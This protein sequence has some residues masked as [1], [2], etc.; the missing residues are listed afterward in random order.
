M[1]VDEP[2][3]RDKSI[4]VTGGLGFIG[5]HLVDTLYETNDVTVIDDRS[6]ESSYEPPPAVDVVQGDVRD[7]GTLAEAMTDVN[8]VF[9]QAALVS[10]TESI[11][12]PVESHDVNVGGTLSV[13]ERAR[14]EDARVVFASSTAI[15]GEPEHLPVTES[16][17][18]EP[19]SPYG[20]QKLS[21]DIYIRQ[22]ADLYDLET[23]GLRYF[24]VYGPRQRPGPYGGVI[25]IFVQQALDDDPITVHGNG[26]QT[27]DFIHIDDVVRANLLAAAT[28]QTGMCFNVG[29]GRETSVRELAEVVRDLAGSNPDIVHKDPR[30]GDIRRSRAAIERIQA[31]LGYEPTVTLREGLKDLIEWSK[32]RTY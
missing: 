31:K 7:D 16:H 24:N 26:A 12:H 13:L 10:V 6:H 25:S 1:N 5:S 27:R 21:G 2:E 18:K 32:E 29:T 9:H 17:P 20:A 14:D 3:I 4:L 22:Y 30:E 28:D 11:D 8:I 15:Y 19:L 23:V